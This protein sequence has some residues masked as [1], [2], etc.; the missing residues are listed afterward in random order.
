MVPCSNKSAAPPD[1]DF[2]SNYRSAVPLL[3]QVSLP[4]DG[5]LGDHAEH[6][7]FRPSIVPQNVITCTYSRCVYN[8]RSGASKDVLKI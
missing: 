5:F 3:L 6:D 1:Y 2:W 7:N 8:T 4:R